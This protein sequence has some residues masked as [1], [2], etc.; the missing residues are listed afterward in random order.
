M[1]LV[2]V[3]GKSGHGKDEIAGYLVR[4]HGFVRAGWSDALK[5]EV[6]TILREVVKRITVVDEMAGALVGLPDELRWHLDRGQDAAWWDMRIHY[7]LHV[8]RSPII[9]AL[10]Q[11]WGTELRRAEA[12]DY[13][14][15]AWE[16][17][18]E[19]KHGDLRSPDLRVVVPDTRFPN[20]AAR[21]L[22]HGG[23]LLR[24]ERPG[25]AAAGAAGHESET[26]LD[27]FTAWDA[28]IPNTGTITE[29]YARVEAWCRQSFPGPILATLTVARA[30]TDDQ[31]RRLE[32][33][34]VAKAGEI[35]KGEGIA[36]RLEVY[37]LR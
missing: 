19:A 24:V 10:L 33:L 22:K 2:G 18:L 25:H 35:A 12:G 36:P 29:L 15:D 6:G 1:I 21:L 20:E 32:H 27:D 7:A 34:L 16:R 4:H 3:S 11:A 30:L 14:L 13:W 9:R 5:D 31:R 28:V 23:R 37:D 17:R 26:A 8:N